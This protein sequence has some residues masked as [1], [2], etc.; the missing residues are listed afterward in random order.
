MPADASTGASCYLWMDQRHAMPLSSASRQPFGP[1]RSPSGGRYR[2]FSAAAGRDGDEG[3]EP[4]KSR[5]LHKKVDDTVHAIEVTDGTPALELLKARASPRHSRVINA[6]GK[7]DG[8]EATRDGPT[9]D[10]VSTP[11]SRPLGQV[12]V[13]ARISLNNFPKRDGSL[14]GA[15]RPPAPPGASWTG[16]KSGQE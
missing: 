10:L 13:P 5:S 11:P 12:R 6:S 3:P 8:S 16:Q 2:S 15:S 4:L 9:H 1:R 7:P 14:P